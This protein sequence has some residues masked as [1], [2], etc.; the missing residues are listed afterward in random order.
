MKSNMFVPK[1]I[2]VGYQ[3]RTGTYTGKLAYVIYEDE[4]GKLRKETSWNSWRDKKIPAEVF[5]N[6]PTE[7]F[8]LNKGVGGGRGWDS[9]NEYI[10]VYDPRNFEIEISVANLLFILQECTS[11]KGKGLDGEFVYVM[12][13]TNLVLLPV[14]CKEYQDSLLYSDKRSGRVTKADMVAGRK[15]LNKGMVELMYLG[16][17]QCR[18]TDV[19]CYN[20]TLDIRV[21]SEPLSSQKHSHVFVDTKGKYY[22][23][24]GFTKI[25]NIVSEDVDSDYAQKLLDFQNSALV[26][27]FAGVKLKKW[28]GSGSYLSN[29][30]KLLLWDGQSDKVKYAIIDT[31]RRTTTYIHALPEVAYRDTLSLRHAGR[32][33]RDTC[34]ITREYLQE[35]LAHGYKA[36]VPYAVLKSGQE[37]KIYGY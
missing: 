16:R 18:S 34:G 26:S 14:S 24:K 31:Y 9:R 37:V 6:V 8:V 12:D 10:R 5:D 7:G 33:Y 28:V 23:E 19:Y 1:K 29:R 32:H 25:T 3:D 13:G 15:Y 27:D 35:L 36:V 22:L 4:K 21:I 20:N 17:H 2:H 30:D 11:T